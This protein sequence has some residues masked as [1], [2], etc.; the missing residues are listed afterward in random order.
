[1]IDPIC[2]CQPDRRIPIKIALH[3]IKANAQRWVFFVAA[4]V[5][6]APSTISKER[7][8]NGYC[9]IQYTLGA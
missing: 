6:D 5:M 2:L 7:Q 3:T 4:N 9:T 8:T 1:L